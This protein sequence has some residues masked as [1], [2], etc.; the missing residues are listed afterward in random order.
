MMPWRCISM[1]ACIRSGG[2][3]LKRPSAGMS[4][5]RPASNTALHDT[6]YSFLRIASPPS[7][8]GMPLQSQITLGSRYALNAGP[9]F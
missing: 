8:G 4:A 5:A 9:W 7:Y 2:I 1:S 3:A 6:M